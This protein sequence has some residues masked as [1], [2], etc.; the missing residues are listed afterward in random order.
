LNDIEIEKFTK[1]GIEFNE[2]LLSNKKLIEKLDEDKI[3]FD[4]KSKLSNLIEV[5]PVLI[6]N[7]RNEYREQRRLL[8]EYGENKEAID[9]NN[10]IDIKLSMVNAKINSFTIEKNSKVKEIENINRNI[11]EFNKTI[12]KNNI[13]IAEIKE[14]FKKIRNWKV[15]LDM[16]GKNGVSKMV[17]RKTLPI[18][19]SELS[20]ML[21]DVCDFD[22]EVVLNDKNEVMFKIIKDGTISN[23]AGGSGFELTASALA[24]RCVLGNISTMPRPNFITLDEILGKVAEDNYESIRNMYAKI[25]S[26]Y[27][28]I[29]HI[30]H[31]KDIKDWHK[32]II[33]VSKKDNVSSIITT[34]NSKNA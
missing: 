18:I 25:E 1:R 30:S 19:N 9:L 24:L 5:L 32:N 29:L 23:L 10:Q 2:K 6:D 11:V 27:Q 15:Y 4:K 7:L 16:V 3:N 14:E 33:T 12:D 13:I 21:D 8:K 31:L 17:L 22:V 28:F 26:S 34:I 20:R